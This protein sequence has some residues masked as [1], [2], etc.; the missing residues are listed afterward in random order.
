[1]EFL[2]LVKRRSFLNEAVYASLNVA[3][4]IG[5]MIIIRSTDS[6]LPAF[7]LVLL[8]KWR[9]LAVRPRYW[10]ANIQG[11][12]VSVIVSI[13]FVVFL[14]VANTANMGE[15][16]TL[17]VQ[18]FLVALY[19]VWLLFLKSQSKRKFVV[20]QAGVALFSG[21]TAIYM[22]A[23]GWISSIVVLLVWLVGY[24]TARHVLNSYDEENHTVLLSLAWGLVLAEI[25]W[26]AYHWTIAYSLPIIQNMLLPQVSVIIT[27]LGFVAY[28][29]YNSY[30][31]FKK[32]R[33][34]DI[35]LPLLFTVAIVTVL[36]LAFNNINIGNI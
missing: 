8:S 5:L 13:S 32:I 14:Y 6:L 9:V 21:I 16:K 3:L 17:I 10:F 2:K 31:H 1:M 20:M 26:L 36:V 29:A 19:M 34:S 27:C 35:L 15:L 30:Y 11:D 28:K 23:Y 7:G 22:M 12:L 18:L 4:A 33:I 24:A 25:G